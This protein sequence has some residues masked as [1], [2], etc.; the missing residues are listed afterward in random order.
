M[1]RISGFIILLLGLG[2]LLP[3]RKISIGNLGAPGSAFFPAI[4]AVLMILL[5]LFLII[6]KRK[7][8]ESVLVW[9]TILRRIIPVLTA[10]LVYVF[11]LEYLGFIV[12][13][14]LLM[15]FLFMRV[16]SQRWFLAPLEAFISI[17]L[18]YLLFRVLMKSNLPVGLLGF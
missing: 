6:P 9:S 18:A 5:S 13:G 15:T 1:D 16:G 8:G 14:V 3:G 4:L 7:E 17:G 11:L 12:T 10:L 2:I